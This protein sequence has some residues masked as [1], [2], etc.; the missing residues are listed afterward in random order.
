MTSPVTPPRR[1]NLPPLFFVAT[2]ISG[3]ALAAGALGLA[4]P[5]LVPALGHPPVAWALIGTGV[6]LEGWAV[7]MVLAAARSSNAGSR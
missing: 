4:S 5:A 7:A 3:L 2:A 6:A 1:V